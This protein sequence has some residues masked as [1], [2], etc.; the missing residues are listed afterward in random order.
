MHA[1]LRT[2]ASSRRE[3]L[4]YGKNADH[5]STVLTNDQCEMATDSRRALAYPRMSGQSRGTVQQEERILVIEPNDLILGL[6]ER[7][8]GE[9][10]Y[11]VVVETLQRLSQATGETGEPRLVI[12]D[13]PTPN[14]A[15][16]FVSSVKEVHASPIL[17]LSASLIRS[18]GSSTSVARRF[19]V[20]KVLQKPF[21]RD[22]LLSAVG[23]AIDSA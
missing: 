20:R 18:I 4:S 23:Q 19:G 6:L 14:S 22:E 3:T 21:T 8:L 17:L 16:N 13:V 9:A 2:D 7:W 15:E 12:I 10:G 11:T 1:K 5:P